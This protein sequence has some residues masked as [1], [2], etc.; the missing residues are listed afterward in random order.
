VTLLAFAW[1]LLGPDS[2]VELAIATAVVL[3]GSVVWTVWRA[4][5]RSGGGG[6]A[7]AEERRVDPRA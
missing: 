6:D 2:A 1:I 3:V 4:R 7:P 5:K